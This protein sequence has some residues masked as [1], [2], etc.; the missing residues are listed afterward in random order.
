MFGLGPPQSDDPTRIEELVHQIDEVQ[1]E[2]LLL[3]AGGNDIAGDEFFTL[4]NNARSGLSAVNSEGI[5]AVINGTL[6][7]AYEYL[8]DK[9]LEAAVSHQLKMPIFTH[10]YDYP[11]PD[12]RPA[13]SF[14]GWKIGPWLD[15]SFN[16]KNYPNANINQL[17]VRHDVVAKFIDALHNMLSALAADPKYSGKVFHVDLRGTLASEADWA[18]E[19][20][21]GNDGFKALA[22]KIDSA[23]Q[24]HL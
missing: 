19:L 5:D 14:L 15:E 23:L 17:T 2:A 12:G 13:I 8:I 6:K 3:S 20:H 11:W 21:P 18:N 4:I 16:A 9:A 10:S 1:P 22:D 24:S 7:S